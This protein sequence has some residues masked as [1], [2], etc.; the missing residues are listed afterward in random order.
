MGNENIQ[1]ISN[2]GFSKNA[3]VP[4]YTFNIKNK[5]DE[6]ITI[7]ISETGGDIVFMNSDKK[8]EYENMDYE[9]A[10]KKGKEFLEQKG[11]MNMQETY[12]L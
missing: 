9:E 8:V 12:Y 4:S 3:P 2:Y 11:F 1:E 10:N 5:N 7:S 6:N